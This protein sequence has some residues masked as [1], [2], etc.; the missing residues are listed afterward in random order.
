MTRGRGGYLPRR[1][2]AFAVALPFQGARK[3]S[4]GATFGENRSSQNS[5]V[6]ANFSSNMRRYSVDKQVFW[7]TI[8]MR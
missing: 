6:A 1:R 7:L 4:A 3:I 2:L 5:K 8:K